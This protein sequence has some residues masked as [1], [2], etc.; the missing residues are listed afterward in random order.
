[1]PTLGEE[2]FAD[3]LTLHGG[4]GAFIS[5]SY[6]AAL[7]VPS[8]LLS[9]LPAE[10]FGSLVRAE[11]LKNNVDLTLCAT[12]TQGPPQITVAMVHEDDRAFLTHQHA[13]ALP[14]Q[15]E[16]LL[17]QNS[18]RLQHLHVGELTTL[19]AYPQLIAIALEQGLSIS[20]DCAWDVSQFSKAE[21]LVALISQLDVFLPSE[22]EIQRLRGCGIDEHVAKL[23][24]VKQGASGAYACARHQ[25]SVHSQALACSVVD[26]IG[27]G[28]AFN[29]GFIAAWLQSQS[30]EEALQIANACGAVAASKKGGA[31][32]LPQIDNLL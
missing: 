16:S 1:M 6:F 26:T 19:M 29:S 11:A 9:C 20:A 12:S 28:D 4:G 8:Y 25:N 21:E 5:A 27:A 24:V 15:F 3:E 18:S 32:D 22:N 13:Q 10:P 31:T 2:T 17:T 30:I 23:T 7:G 14:S